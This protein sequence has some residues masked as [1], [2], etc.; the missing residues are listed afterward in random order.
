[1]KIIGVFKEL[2][3]NEKLIFESKV[4]T[5]TIFVKEAEVKKLIGR[6][7][8]EIPISFS[9]T[10]LYLT[11]KRLSF[12]IL[13][14]LEARTISESGAPKL[15]GVAGTWFE[16]P[17]SAI[18]SADIRPV[19]LK[20]FEKEVDMKRLVE[21]GVIKKEM[22][23]RASA[24]ELIYSEEDAV[25]RIKDYMQSLLKMGFWGKIFKK[26]ERVSDKLMIVGEEATTI[27]PSIKGLIKKQ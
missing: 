27:V 4:V 20:S 21:W 10:N 16:I 24:V 18:S 6:E 7:R 1:M 26:I 23:E 13:Y 22:A 3:E 17:V 8:R 15:S 2:D 14:Q 12:L 19:F 9:A 5:P 11:N 25:G